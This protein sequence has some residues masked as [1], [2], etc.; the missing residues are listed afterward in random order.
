MCGL[1][2]R[3][4]LK[5]WRLLAEAHG[6]GTK[7]S[8]RV[9]GASQESTQRPSKGKLG[10]MHYKAPN[11]K[12]IKKKKKPSCKICIKLHHLSPWWLEHA[13]LP[14]GLRAVIW[15]A[16]GSV[17]PVPPESVIV[18][19][20]GGG[21]KRGGRVWSPPTPSPAHPPWKRKQGCYN[22]FSWLSMKVRGRATRASVRLDLLLLTP[23]VYLLSAA[24]P[25]PLLLSAYLS[26]SASCP[27]ALI[28]QDLP[29]VTLHPHSCIYSFLRAYHFS[30]LLL[31]LYRFFPPSLFCV[32]IFSLF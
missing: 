20:V 15:F 12:Q 6:K 21:E 27:S 8:K 29:T 7:R 31:L 3:K 22:L 1:S 19:G 14:C 24:S 18:W 10:V 13:L 9:P 2:V 17:Q 5:S 28:I 11:F 32:C 30:H 25:S 16:L 26:L 4:V 23:T